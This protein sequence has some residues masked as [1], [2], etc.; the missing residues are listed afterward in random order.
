LTSQI[1][2]PADLHKECFT[3]TRQLCFVKPSRGAKLGLGKRVN[4]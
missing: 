1:E 2:A 3:K 4:P